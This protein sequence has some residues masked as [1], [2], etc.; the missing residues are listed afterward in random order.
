MD[1]AA[2]K[3]AELRSELKARGLPAVGKKAELAA[4]L[5]AALAEQGDGDAAAASSPAAAAAAAANEDAP[6]D[7]DGLVD[8]AFAVFEQG[9]GT[10]GAQAVKLG[11]DAPRANHGANSQALIAQMDAAEV[12][13]AMSRTVLDGIERPGG[14][15]GQRKKPAAAPGFF[16]FRSTELTEEVRHDLEVIKMRTFI[17]PKKHYKG[18]D[19]KWAPKKFQVGTVIV[20]A[21]EY[22][23]AGMSKKEL[24]RGAL[25]GFKRDTATGGYV[26][27]KFLEVQQKKNSGGKKHYKAK[28]KKRR[29]QFART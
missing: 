8:S 18:Q 7:I 6:V 1:P 11:A 10:Q 14:E 4:A 23:S 21:H 29:P 26:K 27:R 5:S 19:H 2:M 28:M 22:Y 12:E 9:L 13:D 3:V 24:R 25:E 15:L 20:P 16:D 17:N